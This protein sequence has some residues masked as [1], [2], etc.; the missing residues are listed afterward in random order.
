M[1][2]HKHFWNRGV[3][4]VSRQFLCSFVLYLAPLHSA[5]SYSFASFDYLTSQFLY[6][7]ASN[8]LLIESIQQQFPIFINCHYVFNQLHRF[9]PKFVA[10]FLTNYIDLNR[11]LML[12]PLN[13]LQIT[14]LGKVHIFWKGRKILQN[15][16]L[17]FEWPNKDKSKVEI[18]QN[19]VVFS[20]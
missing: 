2:L 7:M 17:T 8:N 4:V 3:I 5:H 14:Y 6:S 12:Y 18:S 19:F 16:H 15:L 20:E 10:I 9:K 13:N 1:R 11:N